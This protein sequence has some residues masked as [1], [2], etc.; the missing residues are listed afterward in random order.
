MW[1]GGR[2]KKGK[3]SLNLLTSLKTGNSKAQTIKRLEFDR[4]HNYVYNFCRWTNH[5]DFLTSV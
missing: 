4:K 1:E 5:I 2:F 3:I